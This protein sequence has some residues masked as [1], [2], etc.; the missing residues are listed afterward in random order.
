MQVIK[1]NE[2]AYPIKIKD[3]WDGTV[4]LTPEDIPLLIKELQK[5]LD[6]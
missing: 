2:K 3:A 5:A 6:K 1:T 4:Y